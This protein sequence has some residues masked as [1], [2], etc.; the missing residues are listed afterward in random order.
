MSQ[1]DTDHYLIKRWGVERTCV[2]FPN[3]YIYIIVG[4]INLSNLS[5]YS[6]VGKDNW[7]EENVYCF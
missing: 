5:D 6:I 7:L 2:L 3:V 1:P 4:A